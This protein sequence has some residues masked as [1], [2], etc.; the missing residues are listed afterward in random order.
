MVSVLKGLDG[1]IKCN[2][3]SMDRYIGIVDKYKMVKEIDL[4]GLL[5]NWCVGE[6]GNFVEGYK[7]FIRVRYFDEKDKVFKFINNINDLKEYIGLVLNYLIECG[8][9]DRVRIIVDELNNLE[10]V[11]ECIEFINFIV[12]IY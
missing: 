9:W 1:K 3:E 2:F 10:V 6:F 5:G 7:D 11:K 12:G 4:F 8:L